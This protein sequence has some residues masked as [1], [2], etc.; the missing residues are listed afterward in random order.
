MSPETWFQLI[1][2]STQQQEFFN[3]LQVI[4][5]RSPVWEPLMWGLVPKV[6][7]RHDRFEQGNEI[8]WFTFKRI[9]LAAGWHKKAS[10]GAKA[11]IKNIYQEA[12]TIVMVKKIMAPSVVEVGVVRNGQIRDVMATGFSCGLDLRCERKKTQWWLKKFETWGTKYLALVSRGTWV[13]EWEERS[14]FWES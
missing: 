12:T 2:G 13:G 14:Q 8:I 9:T 1:W 10:K 11:E 4:L 3:T 5:M 7:G 6:M